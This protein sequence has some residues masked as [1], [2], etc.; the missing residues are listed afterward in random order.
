MKTTCFFIITLFLALNL[1]CEKNIPQPAEKDK[2][3]EKGVGLTI[4]AD[5]PESPEEEKICV[6]C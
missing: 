3:E 6:D 2:K 1:S 4:K 5:E